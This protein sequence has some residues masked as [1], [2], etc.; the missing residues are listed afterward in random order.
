MAR[1]G[2]CRNADVGNVIHKAETV[3]AG[4]GS[5]GKF[6]TGRIDDAE[7]QRGAFGYGLQGPGELNRVP[8]L[9]Y[10][11]LDLQVQPRFGLCLDEAAAPTQRRAVLVPGD[12]IQPV[13]PCRY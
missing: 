5:G 3:R 4:R 10:I 9:V 11:R 12:H 7:P 13:P 8:D 6:P 1:V 2:V